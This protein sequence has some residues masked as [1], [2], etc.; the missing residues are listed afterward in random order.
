M[1]TKTKN[2]VIEGVQHWYF[3]T[4]GDEWF[5]D[6]LISE[7]QT[8]DIMGARLQKVGDALEGLQEIFDQLFM[9]D[10]GVF[11]MQIGAATM[12]TAFAALNF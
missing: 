5:M 3:G 12:I 4:A 11:G 9:S 1:P 8:E 10:K 7:L 2:I 6:T